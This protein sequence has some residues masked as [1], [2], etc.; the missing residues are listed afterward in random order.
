MAELL[1]VAPSAVGVKAKPPEGIGTD[2]AAMAHVVVLV[3]RR[4]GGELAELEEHEDLLEATGT[5]EHDDLLTAIGTEWKKTPE[6][7]G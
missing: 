6:N 4:G 2:N 1:R 7:E 3:L 5:E